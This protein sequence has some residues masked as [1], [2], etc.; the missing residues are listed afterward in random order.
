MMAVGDTT[1]K[2]IFVLICIIGLFGIA[3]LALAAATLGT[4]NKRFDSI[5]SKTTTNRQNLKSTLAETILIEDLMGHLRQL[6]RIADES[7]GTRAI[8]TRGFNQTIDYIEK[9]LNEHATGLKVMRETFQVRNFDIAS[10]PILL[11]SINETIKNYT[12][13]KILARS[14]FTYVTYSTSANFSDYVRVINIPNFGCLQ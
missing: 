8:N 12:Y 10:D 7:N 1:I 5:I 6:Q 4:L 9:Y 14:D 13:S 2:R 3:T 11:S